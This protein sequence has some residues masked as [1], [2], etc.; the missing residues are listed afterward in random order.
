VIRYGVDQWMSAAGTNW[1]TMALTLASQALAAN[2][3]S[4]AQVR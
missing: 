2:R 1:A 3:T 4:V